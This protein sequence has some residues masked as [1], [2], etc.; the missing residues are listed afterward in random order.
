MVSGSALQDGGYTTL[1]DAVTAIGTTQPDKDIE[2]KIGASTTEPSAITIGAGTWASLKIYPT[3]SSVVCSTTNITLSGAK[4]VTIDGRVNQTGS[5][6]VGATTSLTL[7][8]TSTTLPVLLFDSDAQSNTV[9]YCAIKIGALPNSTGGIAFGA[10]TVSDNGNGLN[11]IDRNLITSSGDTYPVYAIY[12]TGNTTKPN[13]GNQITNNEF[14]N[15]MAAGSPAI[16][17][18]I[19]GNATANINDNY[20][21]SGNSMYGNITTNSGGNRWFMQIG[22]AGNGGSHTI[23]DNFIGGSSA[24]CGGSKMTKGGTVVSNFIGIQLTTPANGTSLVQ[25]NTI[26][27]INWSFTST[28]INTNNFNGILVAGLGDAIIS[29][30]NIGNNT[31][32]GIDN[33]ASI[34]HSI[35]GSVNSTFTGISISSTGTIT[36]NNNQIGSIRTYNNNVSGTNFINLNGITKSGAGII[37]ISNN[38]IGSPTVA[39]SMS[40]DFTNSTLSAQ[41]VTGINFTGTGTASIS[42]NTIA[43]LTNKTSTGNIYGINLNGAGS[44]GT[45]NANLIHSNSI[46]GATTAINW[47]IGSNAASTN[48]ISNNIV[49]LGDNNSHEIRGIGDAAAATSVSAY[50]NT[51]YLSGAP[52]TLA[53]NSSCLFSL[54]T[55]NTRNYKNNILVNARSNNGATGTHYALNMTSGGTVAVD[56]NAYFVSGTGGVLGKYSSD[57]TELPIVTS[58]DVASVIANPNFANTSGTNPE[59]YVPTSLSLTGVNLSATVPADYSGVSRTT[60]PTMGAHDYRIWNG[61]GWNTAPTS[62]YN[63]RIDGTYTGAGFAALNLVLSAGK[64]LSINSGTLAVANNFTI[65]SD[66]AN[67]TGTYTNTG[68]LTVDGITTVQQYIT[69]TQTGVN[70]RNWYISSPLSASV[71][72]TI[73]TVTG[74]G[75]VYYDGT[76]NWPAAGATMEIMKGYIA[77]SPA[78]PTTINFTGGTLN[79]GPQS[80]ANLPLG[81][82]LVGNPY[83]SYVDFAQATKTNV[84]NSIWYRSKKE[85]TYNFHTYNVTGGISINDGTAIIPPMQSFW[86][87][88]TSATN[89]FGFTNDMR[90][91]QDQ[92]V[93]ANRLKAP[94]A[95]TQQLIRLQVSN[96]TDRD[97]TVIYFNPAAQNSVDEYDTQKMFNN[98]ASKPEIFTKIGNELLVINGMNEVPFNNE[99]PVGF[100]TLTAGDF[101]ISRT[102]LT[103]FDQGT[104]VILKD[105]LN[106]STEFELSEDI[107]YNFNA[108]I[109]TASTDRFSLIFRAP[110]TTTGIENNTKFNAQVFVNASNQITI[111]APEKAAYVIYSAVGQKLTEGIVHQNTTMVD[112]NSFKG[113]GTG[114]GIYIVRV[115]DNEK[116]LTSKLIIQ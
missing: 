98:I 112:V 8:S 91:H 5:P 17:I 60:T 71:S 39:N 50:H 63:A 32:S 1:G 114:S 90:S 36:C 21:I 33:N 115:S 88:T 15:F 104:R 73:T 75:L 43:N 64:Q 62:D 26:R 113:S 107:S 31:S 46:I 11:L 2:I 44:T 34:V 69:S 24:Q 67:G 92:T 14:T 93:D 83:P 13:K 27:N 99:I 72:S 110:G 40:N 87:K 23:T 66:A 42:N 10:T 25:N 102:E 3:A 105:K 57:K 76:P 19:L 116:E 4:N 56:Y 35:V 16:G 29:G 52:T 48:T 97:E 74:N 37:T 53:L 6:A 106:P 12:A 108:D 49:K 82:N 38:I 100:S 109:T 58:N 7:S 20:T 9:K 41:N 68:S 84:T 79:T 18:L 111:I 22:A 45:V 28:S 85:G 95:N 54:N 94:K 65:L 61:S 86:I 101:S 89:T 59:S 77:K 103:N 96:A 81:F 70:G 80:V 55:A 51:V 78:Q 47:G 30:N